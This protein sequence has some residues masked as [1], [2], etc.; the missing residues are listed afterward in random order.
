MA[1]DTIR[2]PEGPA[3][4]YNACF[5]IGDTKV[6]KMVPDNIELRGCVLPRIIS[7][8]FAW[9]ASWPQPRPRC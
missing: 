8:Y 9:C 7:E 1:V 3:L 6:A 2:A 4:N 5:E